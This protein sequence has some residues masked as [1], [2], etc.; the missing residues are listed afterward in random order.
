VKSSSYL[1]SISLA[2]VALLVS[3]GQAQT[4][5]RHFDVA[6]VKLVEFARGRTSLHADPGRIDYLGINIKTLVLKAYPVA[7]YQVVWPSNMADAYYDIRAEMPSDT[8]PEQ[9]HAM[10]QALL[11]ERLKV[12]IHHESRTLPVYTLEVSSKGLKMRQ[13]ASPRPPS[14]L[15]PGVAGSK[16]GWHLGVK[17]QGESSPVPYTVAELIQVFGFRLDRPM[18]DRT[19]L[20]GY[21]DV[22]LV[23]PRELQ[24]D[25]NE[26]QSGGWST[27]AY[28]DA[29]E[30][31]LGLHVERQALTMDMLVVDHLERVPTE[32]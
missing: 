26:L 6:S 8:T 12:Q 2:M 22:D 29:L 10:L 20:N 23:V 7:A 9:L 16:E 13:A 21:Y 18:L 4:G 15:V 27:P 24:T 30:K 3:P 1:Q 11:A 19:G 32:N 28:F 14:S 25:P 31:Q 5:A 17:L